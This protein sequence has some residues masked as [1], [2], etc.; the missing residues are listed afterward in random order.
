MW[1]PLRH[2]GEWRVS[3]SGGRDKVMGE[4]GVAGAIAEVAAGVDG[5]AGELGTQ[6]FITANEL[7]DEWR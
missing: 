4:G 5:E 3:Q 1:Y 2:G 6:A 7:F